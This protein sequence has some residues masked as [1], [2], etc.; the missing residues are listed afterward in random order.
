MVS[1]RLI[2]TITY[3]EKFSINDEDRG[4]QVTSF[5]IELESINQQ[6]VYV[7]LGKE[8]FNHF[9]EGIIYFPLYL[10]KDDKI[11]S[12][13]GLFEINKQKYEKGVYDEDNDVDMSKLGL[14]LLFSNSK[15]IIEINKYKKN[16]IEPKI[17]KLLLIKNPEINVKQTIIDISDS[18]E[19]EQLQPEKISNLKIPKNV[20]SKTKITIDKILENDIFNKHDIDSIK[21]LPDENELT[22]IVHIKSTS[23]QWIQNFMENDSYRIEKI[24]G[25]G[26]CF[27]NVVKNA[28]EQ[29]G[30]YTTVLKLRAIV[31]QNTDEDI[32]NENRKLYD[33]YDILLSNYTNELQQINSTMTQKKCDFKDKSLPHNKKMKLLEECNILKD[34][35]NEIKANK[36]ETKAI[37]QEQFGSYFGNIKTLDEYKA[38]ILTNNFWAE[39]S[40]ILIIEKKL[41]IKI[42]VLSEFNNS[43]NEDVLECGEKLELKEFNPD[44]Y[45]ITNYTGNHYETISYK[46]RKILEFSE[47][48]YHLKTMIIKRCMS[49]TAGAYSIIKDFKQFKTELGILEENISFGNINKELFDSSSV[50]TFYSKSADRKPGKGIGDTIKKINQIEFND[51]SR[52]ANWRRIIDD[53]SID[54]DNPFTIDNKKY[55]SVMHFYQGSKYKIGFPDFSDLFSIDSNSNISKDVSYCIA[56]ASKSGKI[57]I[58]G[59]LIQLRPNDYAIDSDFYTNNRNVNERERAINAKFKQNENF[60]NTLLK[61]N[62][63]QLNHYIGNKAPELAISLMKARAIVI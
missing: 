14:P 51:L 17:N 4:L 47:I 5:E 54:T 57:K 28:F 9:E 46:G 52:I 61:T 20:L 31:A 25:D 39:S 15:E 44:Y 35:F 36:K 42:I 59:N 63:A 55:A 27:F 60:R 37:L 26:D 3:P 18:E 22:P 38:F 19:D 48:P 62:Q 6:D 40:S 8:K 53:S 12:Q 30:N 32:F 2:K 49:R 29:I 1:S 24:P 23:N 10:L 58:K 33:D 21:I 16:T 50:L 13:I 11:I 43:N 45:I 56:A 7:A 34:N 41:N